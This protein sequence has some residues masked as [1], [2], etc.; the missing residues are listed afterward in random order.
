M[1]LGF[2]YWAFLERASTN[3]ANEA[4]DVYSDWVDKCAEAFES[5]LFLK[6]WIA[7]KRLLIGHQQQVFLPLLHHPQF[8]FRLPPTNHAWAG[9]KPWSGELRA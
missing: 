6:V 3:A 4:V 1:S 5:F 8:C 7:R 2:G 9:L